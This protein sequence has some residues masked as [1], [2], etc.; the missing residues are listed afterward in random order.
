M[1]E[2]H[3]IKWV[4]RFDEHTHKPI[5][6]I[7]EYFMPLKNNE[8]IFTEKI[9]WTNIRVHRDWHKVSFWGRTENAQ[10]PVRLLNRLQEL[11][12]EEIFE[13]NFWETPVTLYWEWYGWKIQHWKRDYKEDEDFILFDVN[14]NDTRLERENVVDISLKLWISVVPVVVKWTIQDW[15]DYV[16]DNYKDYQSNEPQKEWLIWVPVWWYLDR[17]WKRIIV[18][19]KKEHFNK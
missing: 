4:F 11:F 16:K 12:M 6:M 13:Q 8:R 2:Y 17:L 14:I 10:I 15:I 1:K 9:D 3:K 5:P 7:D 18:K 19:I